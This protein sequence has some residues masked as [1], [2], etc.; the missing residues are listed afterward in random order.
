LGLNFRENV[1]EPEAVVG[2]GRQVGADG[3]DV[4]GT[5]QGPQTAGHFLAESDHPDLA[6]NRTGQAT[7]IR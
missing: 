5:G 3:G 7:P 6:L 1:E 4:A 2:C